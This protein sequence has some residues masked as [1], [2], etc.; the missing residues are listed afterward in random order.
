MRA[1]FFGTCDF[2]VSSLRSL[3]T[4]KSLTAIDVVCPPPVYQIAC[5]L[6]QFARRHHLPVHNITTGSEKDRISKWKLPFIKSDDNFDGH[7]YDLGIVVSFGY[8][9]PRRLIESFRRGTLNVHPSL[10]PQYRGPAPIHHAIIN[11]DSETGIS[12]IELDPE[13]FDAGRILKQRR[14]A[15]NSNALF[16]EVHSLLANF[17]GQDLKYVVE[18]L[19]QCQKNSLNQLHS[20]KV[21]LLRAPKISRRWAQIRF[22]DMTP[23]QIYNRFRAISHHYSLYSLPLSDDFNGERLL[24]SSILSP[25]MTRTELDLLQWKHPSELS[26]NR[27]EY[28]PGTVFSNPITNTLFIKC[29]NDVADTG[30]QNSWV[31]VKGIQVG[32]GNICPAN[33]FMTAN[34]ISQFSALFD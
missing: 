23:L 1:L 5:P 22:S 20:S 2:S 33:T 26:R 10:L 14:V 28:Q 29:R 21:K 27:I 19:E 3:M 24:F 9:M 18:N 6:E 16:P 4:S 32:N 17:G 12:I 7:G 8:F 25:Q 11:G 34:K 15:L 13:R 30:L 31:G